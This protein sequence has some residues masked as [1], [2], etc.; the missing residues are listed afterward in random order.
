VAIAE[1]TEKAALEPGLAERLLALSGIQGKNR[2][3]IT[4]AEFG[5]A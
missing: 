3:D 2:T 5:G 4:A 1:N